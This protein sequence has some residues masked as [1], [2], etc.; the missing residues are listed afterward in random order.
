MTPEEVRRYEAQRHY[1][2]QPAAR[3]GDALFFTEALVHGTNP[4]TADY[5]S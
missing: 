4:W 1:V 2:V 5:V 3:A